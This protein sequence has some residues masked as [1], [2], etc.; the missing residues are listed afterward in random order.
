MP[1]VHGGSELKPYEVTGEPTRQ[2]NC[3][4]T[5]CKKANGAAYATIVFFK[6]DQ[7]SQLS[8]ETKSY[9][10]CHWKNLSGD[11]E[12]LLVNLRNEGHSFKE[13]AEIF[14]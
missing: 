6:E 14:T 10:S 13:V 5:A 3:H 4:C 7:I 8:G 2:R 12:E 11:H 9:E 1:G